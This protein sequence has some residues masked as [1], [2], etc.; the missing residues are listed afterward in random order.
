M[1]IK[2]SLTQAAMIAAL[3]GSMAGE[4][5]NEAFK[6]TTPPNGNSRRRH[7]AN[8]KRKRSRRL[9]K[10]ARSIQRKSL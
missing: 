9:I 1:S 6:T 3:S 10:K 7:R 5:I 4:R 2:K 8:V